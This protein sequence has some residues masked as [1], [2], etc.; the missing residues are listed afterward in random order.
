[1]TITDAA[2]FQ[3]SFDAVLN[4]SAND[5]QFADV[6]I[7]SAELRGYLQEAELRAKA[8]PERREAYLSL[9]SADIRTKIEA[10]MIKG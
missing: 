8:L 5:A 6:L 4:G 2:G 3:A 10:V 1:M 7:V 9:V